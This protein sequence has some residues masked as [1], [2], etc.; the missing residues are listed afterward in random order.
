MFELLTA[1]VH[2][3]VA[4]PLRFA[5]ELVQ[6]AAL[7]FIIKAGAF[8]VGKS[9]GVLGDMLAKRRERVEAQ[10]A[11]IE[12]ADAVLAE[13]TRDAASAV[14]Q[15][16]ADAA[17]ALK[18]ARAS[19]R[20]EASAAKQAAAAE[21]EGL[22][23]QARE[24][25]EREHAETLHG[26]HEQLVDVVVMSTRQ[27]L[28]QGMAPQEQRDMVRRTILESLDDLDRVALS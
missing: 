4:D 1:A 12:N 21:A 3:I 28:D 6:F 16:K 7:V 27:M 2:E 11:R 25:I 19:A 20:S 5:I 26:I 15:A 13:A 8:G 18:A 10:I 17:A 24:S 22:M 9:K 23:Q 14:A